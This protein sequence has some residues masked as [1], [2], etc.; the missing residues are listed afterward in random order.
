MTQIWRM[1]SS[2][3]MSAWASTPCWA[4][5]RGQGSK[6]QSCSRKAWT[7]LRGCIKDCKNEGDRSEGGRRGLAGGE[8]LEADTSDVSECVPFLAEAGFHQLW[9]TDWADRDHASGA[10]R[11]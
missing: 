5:G 6:T 10:G 11:E 4:D 1:K 8:W 3:G 9:R 2:S 7:A